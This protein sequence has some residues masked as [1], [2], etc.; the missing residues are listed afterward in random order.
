M[1]LGKVVSLP[2]LGVL[3][4]TL[5]GIKQRFSPDSELESPR[6]F[7]KYCCPSANTDQGSDLG[8][9]AGGCEMSVCLKFPGGSDVQLRLR[10]TVGGL[11]TGAGKA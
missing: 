5:S 1:T 4:E 11:G 7:Q 2:I 10:P 8:V 6:A 3:R 9:E